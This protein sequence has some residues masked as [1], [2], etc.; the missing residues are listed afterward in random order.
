M[1]HSR[2]IDMTK[3]N[4]PGKLSVRDVPGE[5][6]A[7][8]PFSHLQ[9]SVESGSQAFISGIKGTQSVV[10][11]GYEGVANTAK[12]LQSTV[13]NVLDPVYKTIDSL[14][15][16]QESMIQPISGVVTNVT[17]LANGMLSF[18]GNEKIF[19]DDDVSSIAELVTDNVLGAA[20]HAVQAMDANIHSMIG[21]ADADNTPKQLIKLQE[22]G[23]AACDK[24]KGNLRMMIEM[25][26]IARKY[27]VCLDSRTAK[28]VVQQIA[29]D[30]MKPVTNFANC[31][32]SEEILKPLDHGIRDAKNIVADLV[33]L[34]Q[35]PSDY[36][37]NLQ[38]AFNNISKIVHKGLA[39]EY[40][41][42]DPKA[43]VD[44]KNCFQIKTNNDTGLDYKIVDVPHFLESIVSTEFIAG[45]KMQSAPFARKAQRNRCNEHDDMCKIE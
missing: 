10:Q 41:M 1:N 18:L 19:E 37:K 39:G 23:D 17:K 40:F 13:Q 27:T 35:K 3:R 24:S 22:K 15:K 28:N 7:G 4:T 44:T 21:I 6:Y 8:E 20:G 38:N 43:L 14:G 26:G 32:L 16:T 45:K 11:A 9:R 12:T 31:L 42:L 29:Q 5:Q 36:T 33:Y 34:S 30:P 25:P 2:H